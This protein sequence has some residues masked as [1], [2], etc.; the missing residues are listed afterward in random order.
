LAEWGDPVDFRVNWPNLLDGL[1]DEAAL[2]T[3]LL[4]TMRGLGRA[5]A[6]AAIEAIKKAAHNPNAFQELYAAALS[7]LAGA[8]TQ[9]AYLGRLKAGLDAPLGE[10]DHLFGQAA[11]A[12]Q[13]PFWKTF[14]AQLQA[15]DKRYVTKQEDGSAA[16]REKP[17]QN[18][19]DLYGLRVAGSANEAWSYALPDGTVIFWELG[20]AEHHCVLCPKI[21]DN[22]PYNAQ[23]LPTYPR[24]GATDCGVN[25]DC[26][27]R[28]D[29][30]QT[31]FI[32]P[33]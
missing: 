10:A 13:A 32:L 24:H 5:L 15:G 25:C 17:I 11:A 1:D 20:G 28:T 4:L 8:H 26:H 21:A 6:Q 16:P 7:N 2:L 29:N 31:S 12:E 14:V 22:G 19:S 27:L 30:G 23:S 18:R 9:G 33:V 3:A